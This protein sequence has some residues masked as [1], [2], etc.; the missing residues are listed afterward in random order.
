MSFAKGLKASTL[1]DGER[2]SQFLLQP[3]LHVLL[4]LPPPSAP[5]LFG[6]VSELLGGFNPISTFIVSP[7]AITGSSKEKMKST[8]TALVGFHADDELLWCA[9]TLTATTNHIKLDSS[10]VL[11]ERSISFLHVHRRSIEA[12]LKRTRLHHQI[13]T[14]IGSSLSPVVVKHIV[15]SGTRIPILI[16]RTHCV[17]W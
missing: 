16:V 9:T 1:V 2:T 15:L 8:L 4:L 5:I 6:E 10:S 3:L 12:Q 17:E 14:V 13:E 11:D 7:P